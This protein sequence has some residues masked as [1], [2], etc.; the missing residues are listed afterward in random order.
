M[1]IIGSICYYCG[2]ATINKNS[3]ASNVM[4]RS[5]KNHRGEKAISYAQSRAAKYAN[6][7][8]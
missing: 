3:P 1:D 2:F 8:K 7:H 4:S 6:N 5:W